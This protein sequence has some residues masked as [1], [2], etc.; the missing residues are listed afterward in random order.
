[1]E[2]AF[3]MKKKRFDLDPLSS[4][5]GGYFDAEFSDV[6]K[7]FF[8]RIRKREVIV[9][10]SSLLEDELIDAPEKVRELIK[11]LPAK[12]KKLKSQMKQIGLQKIM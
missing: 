6:S 8:D 11:H 3:T 4:V 2:T 7:K 5:V 12:S 1:M 10:I 9:I